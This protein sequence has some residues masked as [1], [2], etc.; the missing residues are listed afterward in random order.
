METIADVVVIPSTN[1]GLVD[2]E[3]LYELL[4]RYNKRKIKIAAVTSYSNVTGIGTPFHKIAGVMH[5]HGGL[6]FVDFAMAAPYIN[7]DMHP[8]EKEEYLDAIYFSPHKFLGGP[9]STGILIFNS[10]LY[11][12]K[13]PDCPGGGTVEWTNPWGGHKYVDDI[14]LRED[15]G[16]PAFLQTI[17]V[18]MAIKLKEQMGVDNMRKR[19]KEMLAH[20]WP[21]LEKIPNLH[22]LAGQIK[23][24]LG[25]ISFYIDN[26]HYNLAVKVLND[27][28]G[29]QTRGGCSCA[30]TY[31]HFLLHVDIDTSK[32]IT[33]KISHGD[34][35]LKPGWV[36]MSIHP[37]MTNEEIEYILKA[38]DEISS[39][40]IEFGKEYFYDEHKNEYFHTS[41]KG[42]TSY[43]ARFQIEREFE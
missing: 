32:V 39:K 1:E 9:G 21:L 23:D 38:I 2:I 19:E 31:G 12:N 29:I 13:I 14:E 34:L 20:I 3:G 30:G 35:S 22:I 17:K 18:A 36:R 41:E 28:Y 43:W 25:I 26:L 24:R 4:H 6:C 10:E 8:A 7:I 11:R 16:T 42:K 27:K 5:E 15:G 33:D 37:T 40:H